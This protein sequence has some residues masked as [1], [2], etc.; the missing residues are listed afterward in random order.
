MSAAFR[1]IITAFLRLLVIVM[2]SMSTSGPMVSVFLLA[3]IVVAMATVI[4]GPACVPRWW[5]LLPV[6][7]AFLLL[8]FI[9][10][11]SLTRSGC[12]LA[13]DGDNSW[14]KSFRLMR[15]LDCIL[16]CYVNDVLP[17]PGFLASPL[18]R[19]GLGMV[20]LRF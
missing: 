14:R 19:A 7:P 9:F 8:G 16:G 12:F 1:L 18:R 20:I 5:H 6:S 3:V 10:L 4:S 15:I 13:E 2:V 11:A 17:I